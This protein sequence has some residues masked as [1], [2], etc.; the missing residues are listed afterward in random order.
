MSAAAGVLVALLYFLC[1]TVTISTETAR[2][3]HAVEHG[4]Q[5]ADG[6]MKLMGCLCGAGKT[7]NGLKCDSCSAGK[8]AVSGTCA[9][10][11]CQN[12]LAG[13]FSGFE[14]S[15]CTNCAAGTY[16]S[17]GSAGCTNCPAGRWSA[18]AAGTCTYCVAGKYG[19][20]TKSTSA[21]AACTGTCAAGTYSSAGATACTICVAGTYAAASGSSAC[22][23]CAANTYSTSGVSS[24]PSCPSGAW[25]NAGATACIYAPMYPATTTQLGVAGS[26]SPAEATNAFN[27]VGGVAVDAARNVFASDDTL[28]GTT[29]G[30]RY[31]RRIDGSTGTITVL[32][33]TT[34]NVANIAVDSA[35]AVYFA[36]TTGTAGSYGVRKIAGSSATSSGTA[37]LLATSSVFTAV[38]PSLTVDPSGNVFLGA[39]YGTA[40]IWKIAPGAATATAYGTSTATIGTAAWNAFG[41][42]SDASGN[43]YIADGTV[44]IN[45]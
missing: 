4:G 23:T 38:G 13:K 9:S 26:G 42:A 32:Y 28:A 29:V 45:P 2:Y 25:T 35:G 17:A 19:T 37:T 3:H 22:A 11:G 21:T 40:G 15:S 36:D 39:T 6:V 44:T 20:I 18:A 34:V 7:A 31:V 30:S 16:S 1:I 41:M 43:L 10:T 33:T 14:S 12:C 5:S 8:W 24:C 27:Y